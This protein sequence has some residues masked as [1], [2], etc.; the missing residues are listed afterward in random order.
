MYINKKAV[1]LTLETVVVGII[2]LVALFLIAFFILKYGGSLGNVLGDQANTSV[3]LI[4]D[5][6]A[7]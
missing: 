4:P 6:K 3:A 7:P 2:I 1:S 5:I